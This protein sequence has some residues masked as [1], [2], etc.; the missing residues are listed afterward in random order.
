M[1]QNFGSN[2]ALGDS[3]SDLP[4]LQCFAVNASPGR[5]AGQT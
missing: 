4:G 1:Y 2:G 5:P 3:A